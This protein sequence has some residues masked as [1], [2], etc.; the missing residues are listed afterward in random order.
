MRMLRN[1]EEV[2]EPGRI[3]HMKTLRPREESETS[4]TTVSSRRSDSGGKS[5][6][7]KLVLSNVD[8]KFTLLDFMYSG[9]QGGGRGA[10]LLLPGM[11]CLCLCLSLS[12]LFIQS[13]HNK[14][15][16]SISPQLPAASRIESADKR[17]RSGWV[18]KG[19]VEKGREHA[20]QT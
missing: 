12:E 16:M 8:D 7:I 20:G 9:K 19:W 3:V 17:S 6:K 15:S 14:S 1:R 10:D 4:I 13:T 11:L 18:G 5:N 2:E